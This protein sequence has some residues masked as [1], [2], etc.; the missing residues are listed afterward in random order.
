MGSLLISY[1]TLDFKLSDK[2]GSQ[3]SSRHAAK[4]FLAGRTEEFVGGGNYQ[5]ILS[6]A[7]LHVLIIPYPGIY[8]SIPASSH[9]VLP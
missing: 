2:T 1:S 7:Q 9:R 5:K 3:K 6:I 4:K 8:T